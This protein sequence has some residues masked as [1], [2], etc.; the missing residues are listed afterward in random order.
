MNQGCIRRKRKR[1][2]IPLRD[3]W[4]NET[5]F[6]IKAQESLSRDSICE[7]RLIFPGIP[8]LA[9]TPVP[10]TASHVCYVSDTR[11][12]ISYPANYITNN[13]IRSR[14]NKA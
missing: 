8:G 5:I 9:G 6:W 2:A 3:S 1:F 7:I 10:N 4:L 11:A 12:F 14:T 13:L